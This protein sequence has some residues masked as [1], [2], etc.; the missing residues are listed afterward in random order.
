MLYFNQ[1]K[2]FP[3]TREELEQQAAVLKFKE[4]I[5]LKGL[6]WEY[7]G[8]R[9]FEDLTFEHLSQYLHNR[10]RNGNAVQKPATSDKLPL[11][12]IE[13]NLQMNVPLHSHSVCSANYVLTISHSWDPFLSG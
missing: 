6:Y 7:S 11:K 5:K 10:F 9:Q 3:N 8:L 12:E 2:Y 13:K 4:K 1:K